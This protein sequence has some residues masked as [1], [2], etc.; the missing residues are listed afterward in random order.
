MPYLLLI[1]GLLIGAYALYR[2]FINANI[3][4]IKA[5][6]LAACL[7]TLV[8]ALFYMAL[9]GKLAAALGLA[10]AI[11]PFVIAFFREKNSVASSD[12]NTQTEITTREDALE[13]LGLE[14][15]ASADDI[16]SAYKKLM[17]KV[18]PD[19]DGSEWMAAKLNQARDFLLKDNS[20][21]E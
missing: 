8:I 16:K 3:R 13:V 15:G 17:Q 9:T 10:A 5:L 6:F 7:A 2:F 20:A 11:V 4:Q 12:K 14:D 21:D 1:F 18:H 19:Q